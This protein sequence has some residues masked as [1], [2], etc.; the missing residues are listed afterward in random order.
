[1]TG[2]LLAFAE[3]EIELSARQPDGA[4]LRE[5][6]EKH[7]RDTGETPDELI[8]VPCPESMLYLWGYFVSMSARRGDDPI[9]NQ[10][11]QAWAQL[12]GIVFAPFEVEA[13]ERLEALHAKI[14]DDKR[15][16]K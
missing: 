1:M 7:G 9:N 13:L 5:H 2:E 4:T 3:H 11:I 16:Q 15:N 14:R 6:L 12:R 8:P 10:E